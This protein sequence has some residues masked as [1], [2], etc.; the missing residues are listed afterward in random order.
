MAS[1]HATPCIRG[2]VA[3]EVDVKEGRAVF[4]LDLSEGQESRP[5]DSALPCCAILHEENERQVPVIV[6]QVET[7]LNN[8][9]QVKI[10]AGYRLLAGGNGICFVH[11]LELLNL[12]DPRFTEDRIAR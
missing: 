5:F 2:R 12:P 9:N 8:V 10:F 6:I 1:W 4:Y 3:S 7:S 11:E